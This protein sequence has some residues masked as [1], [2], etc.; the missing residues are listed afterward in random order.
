MSD[1][2]RLHLIAVLLAGTCGCQ[3]Q[4]DQSDPAPKLRPSTKTAYTTESPS[5]SSNT[6]EWSIALH[7]G[8]GKP[9]EGL[10][11]EQKAEYE[12]SLGEALSV[13]IK[14]LKEGGTS[15]G[16]V[17]QVVRFLEDDPLFN[18]GKGAVFNIE[19]GHELHASIMDGKTLNCG[20]VAAV[21][22]VKNPVS[23]ARLVMTDT[24]FILLIGEGA[25]R[26]AV[27]KGIETVEPSYF[28]TDFRRERWRKA[29]EDAGLPI[30]DVDDMI[31][32][33]GCVARDKH[34]NVAAATS[35]GGVSHKRFGRMGDSSIIG[36]GNY[37]NN[38]TCAISCTG[39]GEHFIRNVVAHD[40]SAL[41]EYKGLGLKDAAKRTVHDKLKANTGGLIA[42]NQ[43]GTI[44]MES[45]KGGM[46]R[47][48]ADS[49]GHT[50]I[51]F[52]D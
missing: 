38:K 48:S 18:A 49:T 21:D 10:T 1:S 2:N 4:N 29:R 39:I 42:V 28:D 52:W 26:F 5:E 19:G 47:A 40:V 16:A 6:I 9:P 35:T 12:K 34:G 11:K 8:A 20:A 46:R 33:V 43:K 44:V 15:L 50:E 41:I 14:I 31:G 23:L 30:D 36:A 32:T 51:H 24:P 25:E 37:A 22:T 45:N 13:G 7:G 27:E 17:E 3:L